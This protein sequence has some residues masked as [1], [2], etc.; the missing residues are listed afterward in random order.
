MLGSS[1]FPIAMNRERK[2]ICDFRQRPYPKLINRAQEEQSCAFRVFGGKDGEFEKSGEA[3]REAG[4]R[5]RSI[6]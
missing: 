6:S 3:L 5:M 4:S 2:C 1:A